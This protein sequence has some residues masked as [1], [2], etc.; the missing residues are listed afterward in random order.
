M[1]ITD[2]MIIP[3]YWY[4]NHSKKGNGIEHWDLL[5]VENG[6]I[7]TAVEYY[8]DYS[9]VSRAAQ[10]LKNEIANHPPHIEEVK[11]EFPL[12]L[13]CGKRINKTEKGYDDEK[14]YG[15]VSNFVQAL[16]WV[17]KDWTE[18]VL[19]ETYKKY[20]EWFDTLPDGLR[21]ELYDG[22]YEVSHH[23]DDLSEW[24]GGEGSGGFANY[25]SV[26]NTP[27]AEISTLRKSLKRS[28]Q[29][30]S[31]FLMRCDISR[32]LTDEVSDRG[33]SIEDVR[34]I[35]NYIKDGTD[36]D[37]DKLGKQ[38]GIERFMGDD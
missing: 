35:L 23:V 14:G 30:I 1:A 18:D 8:G 24:V 9:T 27:R 25:L 32:I 16:D 26:F 17:I 7:L 5:Y 20:W 19:H 37:I 11:I 36:A 22:F 3:S 29:Q 21:D 34:M 6:R 15:V 31:E 38:L 12:Y 33:F 28:E 13:E 10:A 2:T 4:E